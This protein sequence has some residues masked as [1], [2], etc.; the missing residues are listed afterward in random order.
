[1]N[2]NLLPN[3]SKVQTRFEPRMKT[4]SQTQT[5]TNATLNHNTLKS[6]RGQVW[7]VRMVDKTHVLFWLLIFPIFVDYLPQTMN[8]F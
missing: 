8:G 4:A 7:Y 2:P 1:M 3:V 6:R 5:L